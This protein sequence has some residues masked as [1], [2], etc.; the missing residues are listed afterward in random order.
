MID[1]HGELVLATVP[2]E[3]HG[4]AADRIGV[5][6]LGTEYSYRADE[7]GQETS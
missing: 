6:D 4:A 7:V 3:S 2:D 1:D 5:S